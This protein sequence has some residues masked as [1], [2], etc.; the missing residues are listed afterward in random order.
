MT[1]SL[2]IMAQA[3]LAQMIAMVA[4]ADDILFLQRRD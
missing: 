4:I 3:F 1:L 2:L